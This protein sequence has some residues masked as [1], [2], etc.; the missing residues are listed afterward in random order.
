MLIHC[1]TDD[2]FRKLG[3]KQSNSAV[4]DS[5][6]DIVRH[7]VESLGQNAGEISDIG[8]RVQPGIQDFM[9]VL[10]DPVSFFSR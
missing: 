3:F 4:L 1:C 2:L 7:Y 9:H 5:L 10:G 6:A 8:G